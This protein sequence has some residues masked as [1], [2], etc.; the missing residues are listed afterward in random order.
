[1]QSGYFLFQ[2]LDT[3][4]VGGTESD[5]STPVRSAAPAG[6]TGA[7]TDAAARVLHSGQSCA[8]IS[9]LSSSRQTF[10]ASGL[11]HGFILNMTV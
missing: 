7:A 5:S 4:G 11:Q 3:G 10:T 1:M 8:N 9:I 6:G 2:S